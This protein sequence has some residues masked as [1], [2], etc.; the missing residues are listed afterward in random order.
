MTKSKLYKV[1]DRHGKTGSTY[2]RELQWG[3]GIT[4]TAKGIGTE[5]CTDDVIHA[6][7]DPLIA[8][9]LTPVHHDCVDH[10]LWEAEGEVVAREGQLKC[11]VKTLTTMREISIPVISPEKRM[12]YAFLCALS[13]YQEENFVQWA[14][15]WLSGEDRSE[16]SIAKAETQTEKIR[17]ANL[18]N[19]M[20]PNAARAA[21]AAIHVAM[22]YAGAVRLEHDEA[23]GKGVTLDVW[24]GV[25]THAARC[26]ARAVNIRS[27]TLNLLP[28]VL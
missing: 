15:K 26:I 6:Y 7:E 1:T 21:E 10:R 27:A 3:A 12:Q 28:C 16:E 2:N 8:V 24:K 18:A 23:E 14:H 17:K 13:V 19:Q 9:L 4:H 22:L 11:G 5:L 20:R 25:E